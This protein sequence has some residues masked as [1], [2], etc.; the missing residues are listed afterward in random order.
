MY[1]WSRIVWQVM[2][3]RRRAAAHLGISHSELESIG[4]MA[5]LEAEI[6]WEPD[7]GRSMSSWVWLNVEYAIRKRLAKVAREFAEEDMDAWV[8]E[9]Q[10]LETR[11]LVSEALVYLQAQL[12][13]AEWWLL[14]M[15]HGEGYSA[16]EL[17]KELQLSYGTVRNQLCAARNHAM[18]IL[19]LAEDQ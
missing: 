4:A 11:V 16:K 9:D 19:T 18:T 3:P 6:S 13:H 12:S 15:F 14:W 7:G 2:K 10:D 17:S 8:C 5:A 1:E